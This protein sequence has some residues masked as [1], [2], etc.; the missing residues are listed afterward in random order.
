MKKGNLNLLY[1][2]AVRGKNNKADS[3]WGQI[4]TDFSQIPK[5]IDSDKTTN[6]E[7][8]PL[9]TFLENYHK[10][11][12]IFN[13]KVKSNLENLKQGSIL[14]GQQ[15]VVLGGPG[16]IGNKISCILSIQKILEKKGTNL[17]PVFMIGDFDGLQKEISTSYF[18]NPISGKA[19][20]IALDT[21]EIFDKVAHKIKLPPEKWL[22]NVVNDLGTIIQGFKKQIKGEKQ[23]LYIERFS[24]IKTLLR[25][26]FSRSSSFSEMFTRL[27]GII[28]N[29]IGNEGLIFLPTSHPEMKS[30][31]SSSYFKFL[32]KRELYVAKFQETTTEINS[33]GFNTSL[34][35][36][37]GNFSPF[38]IECGKCFCRID[39]EI[40]ENKSELT[41]FGICKN[42]K[43]EYCLPVETKEQISEVAGIL[44]PRVDSSQMVLLDIINVKIRVSGPG[45]IS[46][47]AQ[48]A[49]SLKSIGF[50]NP[51]FVKYKRLFYNTPWN[52]KLGKILDSRGN[53]SLHKKEMFNAIKMRYQG[54]N[55]NNHELI[56]S[57]ELNIDQIISQE[58]KKINSLRKNQD[59]EKYLSWQFGIFSPNK[60]GQEV[61]WNWID[62]ALQTGLDDYINTYTRMYLEPSKPG[63]QH[64]T[65]TNL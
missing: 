33:L 9:I 60:Y 42:C 58:H 4:P 41:A 24:H 36:R 43:N 37:A 25:F 6:P 40:K 44:I 34:R 15:P 54:I 31:F 52:E 23:K 38:Y 8:S 10:S 62:L 5:I 50:N 18:P 39:P 21:T 11:L 17:A 2:E 27:W 57:S 3:Y 26:A 59:L 20:N 35:T 16:L 51:V 64:F 30:Y 61:S 48:V 46:Y 1:D 19:H 12:G 29:K 45:E 55:S 53:G 14:G 63:V 49:P 65:N 56:Q 47:Y 32:E 22:N 28:V 7:I 13:S